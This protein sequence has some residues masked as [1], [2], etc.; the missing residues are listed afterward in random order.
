MK[1]IDAHC[2]LDFKQ[3]K[4]DRDAVIRRALDAGVAGMINSGVDIETN[5]STL[6]LARRYEFIFATLGLSPNT[7]DG[8]SDLEAR[9]EQIEMHAGEVIGI[10]EAGL[11]YYRCRSAP[12]RERQAE[13]FRRVIALA[14]SLGLPLV[15]HSR[16][17]EQQAL[18]M[19]RHLDRVVFHCY[20]GTLATMREAVDRGFYI[21]LAT[22]LCRSGHHQILA[23]NVPLESLLL[24][25][26]SPYLSPFRGRN[27]PVNI[28]ESVGLVARILKMD[29]QE[30]AA[31]TSE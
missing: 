3:F 26:D 19:V 16:D 20:S 27:E 18:E 21:S 28:L 10:G 6:D 2:H 29:P 7:L 14:E 25:T 15:I 30:V 8:Q 31:I 12:E 17:A 13:A 1:V 22:N 5:E 9:L 4:R 23:R 24:E 11:D